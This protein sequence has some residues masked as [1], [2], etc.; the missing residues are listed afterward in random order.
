MSSLRE[1]PEPLVP[2]PAPQGVQAPQAGWRGLLLDSA[3][4]FWTV[5]TVLEVLDLMARYG[6]NRLHWHLTDNCSW[7]IAVPG[8]PLLTKVSSRLPR[9]GYAEYTNVDP[10]CLEEYQERAPHLNNAG[11]Y[12]ED[13]LRKVVS[14]AQELGIEVIPEIDLPGHMEAALRA[15]PELGNPELSDLGDGPW[16]VRN[17]T[18]WRNN[19]LWPGQESFDFITKVLE[20]VCDIFPS[21]VVHL[22]GDE[23]DDIYWA[24]SPTARKWMEEHDV[25]GPRELQGVFMSLARRVLAERGRVAGVWDE[26][27]SSGLGVGDVVFGWRDE[28][29]PVTAAGSGNPWVLCDAASLYFNRTQGAA[30]SG[31]IGMLPPVPLEK[32]AALK[33]PESPNCLGVQASVWCEFVT[34]REE[35]L[36]LLLPRLLAVATRAWWGDALSSQEVM[37]RVQEEYQVLAAHGYVPAENGNN[38]GT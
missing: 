8:Y 25:A 14:H 13:D 10:G 26:A 15:Y 9:P 36:E 33:L 31:A 34:S 1:L 35:L 32:V 19:L 12:D 7:R 5:D 16:P 24:E 11:F 28:V 37:Q 27:V 29:G 21:P 17:G 18:V 30:N 2:G 4:N 38:A 6:F 20:T 23:C 3:R 22:G